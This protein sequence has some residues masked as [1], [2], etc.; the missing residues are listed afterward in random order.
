VAE[1]RGVS[2]PDEAF[3]SLGM[4]IAG[5]REHVPIVNWKGKGQ[6]GREA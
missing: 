3:N 4:G 2:G 6:T 5:F 1:K